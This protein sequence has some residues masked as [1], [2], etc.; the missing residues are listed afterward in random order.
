MSPNSFMHVNPLEVPI[1]QDMP[2][3][4]CDTLHVPI[5]ST[6]TAQLPTFML[7]W[8]WEKLLNLPCTYA[9]EEDEKKTKRLGTA[10]SVFFFY[11][12][13][14]VTLTLLSILPPPTLF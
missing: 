2:D 6:S 11:L 1:A 10:G 4:A 7:S 9:D 14:L 13:S 8:M 5:L 12:G 3:G